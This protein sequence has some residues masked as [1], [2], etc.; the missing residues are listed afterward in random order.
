MDFVLCSAT[1]E[2]PVWKEG[3]RGGDDNQAAGVTNYF[4]LDDA[5]TVWI[6][7][8]SIIAGKGIGHTAS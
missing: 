7:V 3:R 8:V 1:V 6:A 4:K 5:W 2:G